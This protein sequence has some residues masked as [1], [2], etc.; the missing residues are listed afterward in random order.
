VHLCEFIGVTKSF[1]GG[2]PSKGGNDGS[3]HIPVR[4]RQH[5]ERY[6]RTTKSVLEEKCRYSTKR[7]AIVENG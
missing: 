5:T 3:T 1:A 2:P 6:A 7:W 4:T